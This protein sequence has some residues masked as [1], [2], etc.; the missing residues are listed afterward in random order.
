MVESPNA[1][2]YFNAGTQG[3]TE[4]SMPSPPSIKHIPERIYEQQAVLAILFEQDN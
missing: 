4:W 1:R 3:Q 2:S